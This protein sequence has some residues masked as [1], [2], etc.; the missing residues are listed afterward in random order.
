[1]TLGADD[2]EP[3]GGQRLFLQRRH[4]GDDGVMFL[5]RQLAA[6][7]L[8]LEPHVEIAT[9]LDVG[10]APSH[11]GGDGDGTGHACLGD[12][13]RLFGVEARIQHLMLNPAAFQNRRK[14]LRFLD[15][16]RADKHRLATLAAIGDQINDS[17]VTFLACP[18][19]LVIMIDPFHLDIGRDGGHLEP[20]DFREFASLGHRRAGHAGQLVIEPEII[21]ER[22]RG[23]RLV[24]GL[25]LDTLARLDGLMKPFREA[26]P[27]HCPAGEFIDDHHLAALDHVMGVAL[28]QL[29]RPQRLVD[30]M[31]QADILDVVEC[32]LTH[33]PGVAEQLLGMFDTGLGQRHCPP[34]LVK[35]VILGDKMRDDPV[36]DGVMFRCRLGRAGDDQ[37]RARLVDQDRVHLVDDREMVIALHHI[38][39]AEL[40]IVAQIIEAEF[41]V[42]AIGDITAIGG[43][44]VLIRHVAG[45][46]AHRHAK[47]FIDPAHPGGVARG[48]IVIHRD[49]M[50]PL[51][52]QRVQE[53]RQGRDKGLALAGLHFR[54]LALVKRD[55]AHQLHVVMALPQGT[56]RRL[57]DTREGFGKKIVET[58][59]IP[60]TGP[61]GG[62]RRG[63]VVIAERGDFILKGIDCRHLRGELPGRTVTARPEEIFCQRPKHI[64]PRI[65][66]TAGHVAPEPDRPASRPVSSWICKRFRLVST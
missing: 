22:D 49:D 10:A 50:H 59:A 52:R 48:Q 65:P 66:C 37:R 30:M 18:V 46:A 45:D 5:R 63:K 64:L 19:D 55:A 28:E 57:A 56:L 54:D 42:G 33:R 29:V 31:Q 35:L 14:R 20:V 9:K 47:P 32:A 62:D 41:I 4:L 21:L 12:D 61:K 23:N 34:L 60:E 27:L 39:N 58:D 24:L 15:A 51:V 3:A 53:H 38:L 16:D 36:G 43:A 6:I 8:R 2:I 7:G 17:V 26:P 11:V 1:M 13:L 25:D 40:Q 44:A